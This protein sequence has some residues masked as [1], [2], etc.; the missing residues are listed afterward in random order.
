[1]GTG[2]GSMLR[3]QQGFLWALLTI[4]TTA[5]ADLGNFQG[6][7]F[8]QFSLRQATP[9][10]AVNSGELQA[11]KTVSKCAVL[12]QIYN[13]AISKS[14]KLSIPLLSYYP[15]EEQAARTE[16][17]YTSVAEAVGAKA[18]YPESLSVWLAAAHQAFV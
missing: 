1:M 5:V 4:C 10:F 14:A 9:F 6:I 8:D 16:V 3:W 11:A 12:D 7:A 13:F 18:D 2:R 15:Y 17:G